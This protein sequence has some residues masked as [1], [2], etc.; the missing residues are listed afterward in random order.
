MRVDIYIKVESRGN[1]RGHGKGAAVLEFVKKDGSA[2]TRVATT[3][4]DRDTRNAVYLMI[5]NV[6]LRSL[7]KTCDVVIHTSNNYIPCV[8]SNGWLDKWSAN[9][10]IKPDGKKPANVEEWKKLYIFNN[11]HRITWEHEETEKYKEELYELLRY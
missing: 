7:V 3:E 2:V 11:M 10:W 1:P 8:I 4:V 9:N 6:A 5:I